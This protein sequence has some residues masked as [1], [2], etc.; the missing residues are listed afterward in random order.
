MTGPAGVRG[1]REI[2]AMTKV[3]DLVMFDRAAR[4]EEGSRRG[5]EARP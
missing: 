3:D 5:P 2:A 1:G 4:E